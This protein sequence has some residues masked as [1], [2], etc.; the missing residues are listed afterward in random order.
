[1]FFDPF[2]PPSNQLANACQSISE[3]D[4]PVSF[5]NGAFSHIAFL[6]TVKSI[7]L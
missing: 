7:L 3:M 1:L 6:V 2:S 5:E 4:N